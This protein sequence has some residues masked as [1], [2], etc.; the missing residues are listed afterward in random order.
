MAYYSLNSPIEQ[1]NAYTESAIRTF[2]SGVTLTELFASQESIC[3]NVLEH[4]SSK[5][6]HNGFTI[7]NTLVTE[8]D[9]NKIVKDSLNSIEAAKRSK[10]A[11]VQEAEALYIKEIKLAEAD[12]DRKILQGEGTSGQRTA[13]MN[14]YKNCVDQMASSFG[15][16]HKDITDFLLATLHIDMLEHIGKSSNAKTIFID[17]NNSDFRKQIIESNEV[18]N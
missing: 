16:S 8:I 13:I 9:P 14:G 18:K 7:E 2:A 11:A 6:E 3:K 10:E 15:I 17:H 4:L 5:M 12:R 1:M